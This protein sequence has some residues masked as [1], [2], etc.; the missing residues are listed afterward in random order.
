MSEK[1]LIDFET[2]GRI[3]NIFKIAK[4]INLNDV[5]DALPVPTF[6]DVC[7]TRTLDSMTEEEFVELMR[8]TNIDMDCLAIEGCC[9]SIYKNFFAEL[10]H[11]R[12]CTFGFSERK[13]GSLGEFDVHV[14]MGMVYFD[15]TPRNPLKVVKWFL[16]KGFNVWEGK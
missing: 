10:S 15:L 8:L 2:L 5:F 1:R 11:D 13:D 12:I 6:V 9:P 7:G 4:N 14:H 16:E 3:V